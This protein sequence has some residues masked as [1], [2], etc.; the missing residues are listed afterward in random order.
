[1]WRHFNPPW[2]RWAARVAPA[3]AV[4]LALALALAIGG[5]NRASG[6]SDLQ[7]Q[8]YTSRL[9]LLGK[10]AGGLVGQVVFPSEFS[11]RSVTFYLDNVQFSTHPDGRFWVSTI[12]VGIHDL[13]IAVAG[14][15]SVSRPVKVEDGGI[16]T[17]TPMKLYPARGRVLGR[18]VD[19]AG[20]SANG[21]AVYLKPSGGMAYSDHDGIFQ[22]DGIGSGDLAL[23]VENPFQ[24]RREM[25]FRLNADELRNLGNIPVARNPTPGT[26]RTAELDARSPGAR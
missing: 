18:L 21:V 14:F 13:R 22:F 10:G 17:L 4:A 19:E 25:R 11:Q 3:L 7:A 24:L 1:M 15:D 9:N 5:C 2:T 8:H 12:P 20:A 26:G 16:V 6:P 23:E